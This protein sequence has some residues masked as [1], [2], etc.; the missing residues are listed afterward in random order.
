MYTY[1]HCIAL[2][3]GRM[4]TIEHR[5]APLSTDLVSAVYCRAMKKHWE[6]KK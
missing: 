6:I 4:I 5:R 2:M 1:K 3:R